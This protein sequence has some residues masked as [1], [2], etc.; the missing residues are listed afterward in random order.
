MSLTFCAAL[1]LF[2]T[3]PALRGLHRSLLSGNFVEHAVHHSV[4]V[5]SVTL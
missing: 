3:K 4:A 1:D 2:Q 5:L